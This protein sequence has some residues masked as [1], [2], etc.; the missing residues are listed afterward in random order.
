MLVEK[1]VDRFAA[2]Q[3][4]ELFGIDAQAIQALEAYPWPGNIRE[5]ENTIERAVTLE[6]GK[7]L[8]LED[9]PAAI[10]QCAP[11]LPSGPAKRESAEMS[12]KPQGSGVQVALP[13]FLSGKVNLKKIVAQ[14]EKSYIEAA[15]ARVNGKRTEAATLLG[16]N[17]RELAKKLT[18][19]KIK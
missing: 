8:K 16:L 2:S 11:Q 9:F 18:E 4:K 12:K 13:A 14:V 6:G 3:K 5:L 10:Q 15:L 1:F 7:I 17:A 19:L